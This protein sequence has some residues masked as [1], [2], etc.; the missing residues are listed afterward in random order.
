MGKIKDFFAKRAHLKKEQAEIRA[1]KDY[2][3]RRSLLREGKLKK[4]G[5]IGLCLGGGGARGFAHIGVL[6]AFEEYGVKYD[7]CVGTSAGALVGALACCGMKAE[8][9]YAYGEKLSMRDIRSK[10][11]LISAS[12]DGIKKIITDNVGNRNIEDLPTKFCAVATDLVSAREILLTEGE[13]GCAVS[14]SCCVPQFFKPVVMGELHLVDG[15][16]LN[17][18]PADVCRMLGAD[19]V[20]TVDVNPTRYVGTDELGSI[21]VIKAS[22]SIMMANSSYKGYLNSDVMIKVDTDKFKSYSKDGFDEMYALGYEAG[23]QAIPEILEKI[24]F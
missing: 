14:A 4:R 19:Y 5:V 15:G 23:K 24:Y 16:L 17:N 21:A 6:K 13:L 11:L 9:I 2:E 10:N 7:L 3:K 22:F 8:D 20:I 1:Q 18:I 12:T